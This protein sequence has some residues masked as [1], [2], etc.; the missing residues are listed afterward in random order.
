MIGGLMLRKFCLVTALLGIVGTA[1]V[2]NPLCV[3]NVTLQSY[4]TGSSTFANACEI[5]DKLFWGFNLN[6]G[7]LAI[8]AEPAATQIQVQT[9]PGDGLSNIGISFNTGG[10]F[11]SSGIPIDQVLSYNVA[12]ISG[13]PVIKDAT[14]TITGNL[15]GVGGSAQVVETLNP[16]VAGS[17]ITAALPTPVSVNINFSSTMVSTLAVSNRITLIGGRGPT[18]AAH[19][20]VFENDF[21][22]A[23]TVPEPMMTIP[24]GAGLVLFGLARRRRAIRG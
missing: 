21:S 5:G 17:P 11:I 14:L 8:G 18:D 22:E 12:T 16:T 9:I 4:I 19:I 20:S 15:I 6:N 13:Q 2:A 1:A 24:L 7:Q 23:V 3:N 10:W